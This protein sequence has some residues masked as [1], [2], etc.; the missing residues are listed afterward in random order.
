MKDDDIRGRSKRPR[1]DDRV[2]QFGIAVCAAMAT[3]GLSVAASQIDHALEAL[4]S[5]EAERAPR[6]PP[7]LPSRYEQG[8]KRSSGQPV[9]VLKK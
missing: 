7:H 9:Q 4:K 1:A 2:T 6:E 5:V 3:V 8:R